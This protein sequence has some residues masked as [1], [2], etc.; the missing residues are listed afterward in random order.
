MWRGS[1]PHRYLSTFTRPYVLEGSI[2][3]I[4][5]APMEARRSTRFLIACITAAIAFHVLALILWN[6]PPNAL[7][8]TVGRPLERYIVP[9]FLQQ[10][11]FF[12][13]TPGGYSQQTFVRYRIG[14]AAKSDVTPWID[15]ASLF[16]S[17]MQNNPLSPLSFSRTLYFSLNVEIGNNTPGSRAVMALQRHAR[18]QEADLPEEFRE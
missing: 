15:A 8:W 11:N 3:M 7:K 14:N 1:G 6:L 18:V 10:W 9:I 4:R 16:P 12:A 17:E 13:P 2:A 5:V